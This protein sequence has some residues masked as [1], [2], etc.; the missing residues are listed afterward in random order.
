MS[1]LLVDVA[2]AVT[3][4]INAGDDAAAFTPTVTATN[5]FETK[6]SL[7]DSETLHC[8]VVPFGMRHV[9]IAR[10]QAQYDCD[11]DVGLRYVFGSSDTDTDGTVKRASVETYIDLLE[12]INDYCTAKSRRA[13]SGVKTV[14]RRSEMFPW[15]ADHL[16]EHRQYTGILR[17]TY[18]AYQA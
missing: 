12:Q 7:T 17:L 1:A 15:D 10:S 14:W 11:V 2:E 18:T 8:D 4:L 16:R 3:A 13:L 6:L 5:A 9:L